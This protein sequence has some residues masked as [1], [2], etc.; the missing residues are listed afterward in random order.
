MPKTSPS[1]RIFLNLV[2]CNKDTGELDVSGVVSRECYETWMK[3]KN[4]KEENES[5][6]KRFSR[7][8]LNHVSGT[9]S[10]VLFCLRRASP[11]QSN[12]NTQKNG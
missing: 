4:I 2:T 7:T 8:L 9:V 11:S 5:I 3:H 12:A 6:A 1:L 10:F